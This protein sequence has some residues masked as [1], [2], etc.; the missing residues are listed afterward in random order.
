VSKKKKEEEVFSPLPSAQIHMD[1]IT[2]LQY[3]YESLTA[4]NRVLLER[5]IVG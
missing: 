5:L 2:T 4:W 3:N 1:K